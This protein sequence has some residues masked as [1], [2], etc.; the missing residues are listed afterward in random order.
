MN[1]G[2]LALEELRQEAK[3]LIMELTENECSYIL[4]ELRKIKKE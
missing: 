3:A 4:E 1:D 2:K